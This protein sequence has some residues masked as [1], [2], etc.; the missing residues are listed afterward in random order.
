[1]IISVSRRTDIPAFYAQWFMNRIRQGYALVRNPFYPEQ[2]SRVTLTPEAVDALVFITRNPGPFLPYLDELEGR[3]YRYCF[4][5]TLTGY[6]AVLEPHVPTCREAIRLLQRLSERIGPEKLTWRFDPIVISSIS[7]EEA[8]ITRFEAIAAKLEGCSRRVIVSF[9]DYYRKVQAR[10]RYLT[11]AEGITFTDLHAEPERLHALAGRIAAIARKRGM[12]IFACAEKD[13]LSAEGIARSRCID[14]GYLSRVLGISLR[15]GKA[16]NQRPDCGCSE[17]QDI[18]Q[19]DTCLHGCAY[20]Y[21]T[22]S[23]PAALRNYSQHDPHSPCLVGHCREED[24]RG[25]T[26]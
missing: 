8:I 14:D 25:G 4:Q 10:F 7:Q 1:M 5:C 12:E 11:Q 24:S 26:P 19:Y 9:V 15:V 23:L 13:D 22:K 20:C 16:K 21:A 6:P 2:I 17:S 3:G 18:G